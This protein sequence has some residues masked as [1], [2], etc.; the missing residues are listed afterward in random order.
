MAP[1]SEGSN[2]NVSV[3]VNSETENP[4]AFCEHSLLYCKLPDIVFPRVWQG[5]ML[6]SFQ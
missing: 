5:V 2:L 3:D 4:Y 6:T 1:S